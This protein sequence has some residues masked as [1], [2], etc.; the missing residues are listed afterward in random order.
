MLKNRG[1][2]ET[3]GGGGRRLWGGAGGHTKD[4]GERS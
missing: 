3:L 1:W 2:G 4:S